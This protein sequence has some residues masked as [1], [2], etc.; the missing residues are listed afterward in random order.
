M[1]HWLCR[2]RLGLSLACALFLIRCGGGASTPVPVAEE[3]RPPVAE[4]ERVF[5][6]DPFE[7]YGPA[8]DVGRFTSVQA[9]HRR[10]LES[11]DSRTASEIARDLL[12]VDPSFLPG[13]A[14]LG[15]A[16]F[17]EGDFSA[18]AE[19]LEELVR[20]APEYLA[21]RLALARA[22]EKLGDVLSAYITY[23]TGNSFHPNASLRLEE[24]APRVIEIVSNRFG[25]TLR[26]RDFAGAAEQVRWLEKWEPAA[27][28]THEA[29]WALASALGDGA[30]E[31]VA[32]KTL[33]LRQPER[34]DLL[35]RRADLELEMGDAGE[36]VEIYR[37][38]VEKEGAAAGL[39]E[40]LELAKF[41][42][43]LT[44]LPEPIR[45]LAARPALS[46]SGYA[47]LLYWL[48]PEVRYGRPSA[49]KIA[50]DILDHPNRDEIARVVNLG[51]MEVDPTLHV[52]SPGGFVTRSQAVRALVG[53][54]GLQSP[55]P[56]CL[57]E[58][59]LPPCDQAL[60]C[61]FV[62]STEACQGRQ[63]LSGSEAVAL[64]ERLV[65]RP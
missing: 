58:V 45:S 3:L 60:R 61:G 63:P 37:Q 52:F 55:R 32:L 28:A 34:L 47:A 27:T 13:Q 15:Q 44:L 49:A 50:S 41:R 11:Q 24:L 10:L 9:A 12:E 18:A 6:L 7:G 33:T 20:V 48:V 57:G 42:W 65:A 64:I 62:A 16:L 46:R 25:S 1:V 17:V 5:L 29:K 21:A 26:E 14:L 19:V 51:L 38:L 59:G 2:G 31:L 8:V 35:R 4:A 40:R 39:Q 53:A 43:R 30:T 23:R 54:A 36:A 22:Q 56:D